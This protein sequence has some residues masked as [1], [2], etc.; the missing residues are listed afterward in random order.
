MRLVIDTNVLVAALLHPGRT[1]DRAL[2]AVFVGAHVVVYD[3]RIL[4]EYRD[5]FSRKKFRA[6]ETSRTDALL[7]RL[8]AAGEDVGTVARHAGTLIDDDDRVFVE[9]ALEGRADAIV[10]GN[11]KHFPLDL[12]IEVLSPAVLCVRLVGETG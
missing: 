9:V 12:G 8:L 4:A 3:A 6:I 5:V 10:T 7:A 11:A 1:P 2:E